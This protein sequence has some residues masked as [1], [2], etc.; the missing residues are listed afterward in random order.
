MPSVNS[1]CKEINVI[2]GKKKQRNLTIKAAKPFKLTCYGPST[3]TLKQR[4]SPLRAEGITYQRG[5]ARQ[6]FKSPKQLKGK[7]HF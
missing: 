6:Y 3:A 4:K 7:P 2:Y 1:C 5:S